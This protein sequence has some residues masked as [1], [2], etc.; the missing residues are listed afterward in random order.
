MTL[1]KFFYINPKSAMAGRDLAQTGVKDAIE[2]AIDIPIAG[3]G[4]EAKSFLDQPAA[5][6]TLG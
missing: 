3:F 5:I 4:K 6:I 1:S 2:Q